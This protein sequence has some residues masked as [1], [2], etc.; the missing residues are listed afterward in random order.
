MLRSRDGL[1][2]QRVGCKGLLRLDEGIGTDLL[3]C[4]SDGL[5]QGLDM[6]Y[7]RAQKAFVEVIKIWHVL[8]HLI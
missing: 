7:V 3:R 4:H 5:S 2:M 8:G 1:S 6:Q